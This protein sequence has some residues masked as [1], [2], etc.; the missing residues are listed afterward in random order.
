MRVLVTGAFGTL[1]RATIRAAV[2]EGFQI[3]CLDVPTPPNRRAAR[4]LD[5]RIEVVW[6]DVRDPA[7]VAAALAGQ[8]GVIHDAALLPPTT[9]RNPALAHAVNVEGTRNV[10]RA[11]AALPTPPP[12]VFPSSVT[13]FG[14]DPT[15]TRPLRADDPVRA[16]DRYTEHKLAAEALIAAAAIPSVILRVGVSVD[17][18]ARSGD[19]GALGTLFAMDPA[20]RLEWVHPDDVARAQLNALRRREAW[21]RVWLIGG[22]PTCQVR[23]RDLVDALFLALGLGPT[24]ETAFGTGAFY[25][26]WMDTAESELVLAY[27][28]QSFADFRREMTRS[29]RNIRRALTPVRP[30]FRA[31][32]LRRSPAW[33]QRP[34]APNHL[35][36]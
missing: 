1:G 19:L 23:L 6:G 11:L 29:M 17:P 22:G 4:T 9:E 24:P 27:Q 8:D 21:G 34:R 3:R 25:T 10:V 16:T 32:L 26:D 18:T 35:S 28:R 12:I 31:W 33:R 5:R 2:A 14:P 15:R 13:V 30:L 20:S 7:C 36:S